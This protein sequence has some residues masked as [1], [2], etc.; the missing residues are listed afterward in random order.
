[1]SAPGPPLTG[2]PLLADA[3][4]VG[5][6]RLR[7]EVEVSERDLLDEPAH[8]G[9][10]R[11]EVLLGRGV[12]PPRQPVATA[13]LGCVRR[14]RR[15]PVGGGGE[16]DHLDAVLVGL[17]VAAVDGPA[18]V[19]AVLVE[20]R[21]NV[22]Q[23]RGAAVRYGQRLAPGQECAADP[24]PPVVGRHVDVEGAEVDVVLEGHEDQCAADHG[25][26]G[27]RTQQV[28]AVLRVGLRQRVAG[29][30][31]VR[32]EVHRTLGHGGVPAGPP[33]VELALVGAVDLTDLDVS[34]GP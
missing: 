4:P 32:P 19:V 13:P 25:V 16:V 29:D 6:P 12:G 18:A 5:G 23:E 31:P 20:R 1:M 28:D 17:G 15:Q 8:R 11:G 33:V 7:P 34:H 22:G 24:L 27:V 30:L 10:Q 3:Q 2:V 9:G 26:D 14:E 21:A